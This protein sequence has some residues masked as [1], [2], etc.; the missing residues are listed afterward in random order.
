MDVRVSTYELEGETYS[1]G[2]IRDITERKRADEALKESEERFRKAFLTSPDS[3][4]I[5]RLEDGAYVDINEGFTETTGYRREEVIGKSSLEKNIWRNI[6]DRTKLVREL[7]KSGRAKDF[8]AQFVMKDGRILDGLMSAVVITLNNEPCILSTT[9]NITDR[10]LVESNLKQSLEWQEAIFEGSRDSIFISDQDSRFVAVNKA[11]CDLTGYSRD[12]LLKMRIPDLH[13]HPD[14]VAYE[15]YNRRIFD[16]EET[17]TEAKI[18]R[19]DGAKVDT[20]FN[21]KRVSIAGK[22]YMHTTARD[23]T[24]RKRTEVLLRENQEL[25]ALFMRHSPV[26]TYIKEVTPTESR[27]LQASDN[28]H[29]MIGVPAEKMIGRT[30][31]ELFPKEFAAK[32]TAD[33]WGVVSSGKPL[34]LDEE[35][36][37][38]HY[39]TAKFPITMGE[40]K[41]LAGFTIDISERKRAE[42]A[43]RAS[44]GRL[45]DIMFSMGDWVWEVDENGVYTYSSQKGLELFGRSDDDVIGKTPFDFMP[46]DEAKRVGTIFSEIAAKKLPIKDLENWNINK[47]GETICLLT[48]GVPILDEQG[49]L[50]GYR[51]VDK[52]ITDRKRVEDALRDSEERFRKVFEEGPIGMVLTSRELQFFNANPAFC[53][54][55]GYTKEEM[56]SR[57][58]LDVTHPDHRR[59]DRENVEN[60]WQGKIPQYRTEKRYVA[61]NG[62]IRWGSLSASL[63]QG[64]DGQPLYALAMIEDITER[65]RAA[66]TLKKEHAL[67]ST[68]IETI[69]DEICMKD[70]DSRYIMANKASV[71][72]LGAKSSE[73]MIGKT[74][75]DYVRRDLALRLLAEEKQILESGKPSIS[76]ENVRLD[77]KTG[78]ISKCD[79]YTKVPVRAHDGKTI[80]LLVIN[81]DITQRKRAEE[82]VRKSETRLRELSAHLDSVRE[83]ERR[84]IAQEF[85]DQLGQTLTALRMDLSLL[86]RELADHTKGISR[87]ALIEEIRSSQGLIDQG[88]QT[89]RAIMAELRPELLDQLGLLAALEWEAEKFQQRS[90]VLCQIINNVGVLQ[91]DSKRSIALFRIFQE[92]LTNVARHAQA[93]RLDVVIRSE[94]DDLILE[95]SDDGIGITFEAE[96]KSHSFGLIGMRER[97]LLL[98]A[99]LDISGIMGKGTRITVT[100]PIHQSLPDG[101]SPQ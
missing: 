24:Q 18:L 7:Q 34:Q 31:T 39:T 42:M 73:E 101:G 2:I 52:D 66:E 72:A 62:E 98:G 22:L 21:N 38:R 89:V 28:F 9:R 11:A 10:K 50:R 49:N 46:P 43:L 13:D 47:E 88:I 92:A 77:P 79:L 54:M 48:N 41:I 94:A 56:N 16:G 58:F 23:V 91:V 53:Q 45:K 75:F 40:K 44:E 67:L 32:M 25:F 36:N 96:N 93:T 76:R 64:G 90:G 27:V 33:D 74:D 80:G 61:K 69:P 84:H 59:A 17:L 70:N 3:I 95:I 37:G 29:E 83:E 30:M 57:T 26:F 97:A 4:N 55:L 19:S 14:L 78:E 100:M 71:A 63:V 99:K 87:E 51:G 68:I 6:N 65:K 15:T 8:E 20:E 12:Q 35:L 82:R 5:N 1:I 85:H 86:E 81:V 60:M